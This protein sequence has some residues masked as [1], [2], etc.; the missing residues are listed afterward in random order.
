MCFF[1]SS[2]VYAQNNAR[3]EFKFHQENVRSK[4]INNDLQRARRAKGQS[5][6]INDENLKIIF[7]N[8]NSLTSENDEI[9]HT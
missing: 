9:H 5:N 8:G 4:K 7:S 2:E 6:N 1:T 3:R